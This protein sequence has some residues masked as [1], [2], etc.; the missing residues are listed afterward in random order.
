MYGIVDEENGS[1]R[2]LEVRKSRRPACECTRCRA[3]PVPATWSRRGE[4]NLRC[5]FVPQLHRISHRFIYSCNGDIFRFLVSTS[6][7]TA[8]RAE[9][10]SKDRHAGTTSTAS[11]RRIPKALPAILEIFQDTMT[12]QLPCCV[13][14]RENASVRLSQSRDR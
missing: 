11:L 9:D 14:E 8:Q 7:N 3:G 5:H 13:R 2:R 12:M 6:R 1:M 10:N 4:Y